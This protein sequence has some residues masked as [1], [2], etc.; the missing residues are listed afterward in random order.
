MIQAIEYA[1]TYLTKA[2]EAAAY[3][4]VGK[5]VGPVHHFYHLW[6]TLHKI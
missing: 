4:P 1:K 5:G 3:H 2:I 6:P